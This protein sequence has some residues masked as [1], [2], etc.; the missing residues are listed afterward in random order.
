MVDVDDIIAF[1]QWWNNESSIAERKEL[2]RR[3]HKFLSPQEVDDIAGRNSDE[4]TKV[5]GLS[6]SD[7]S[8][9]AAAWPGE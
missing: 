6:H 4:L 1:C 5:G 9:L 2:L 3:V 8:D 7:V